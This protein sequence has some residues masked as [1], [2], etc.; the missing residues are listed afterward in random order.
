[1]VLIEGKTGDR[2]GGVKGVDRRCGFNRGEDR[3]QDRRCEGGGQE[4]WF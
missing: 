2:T 4:V 3:G 1:M